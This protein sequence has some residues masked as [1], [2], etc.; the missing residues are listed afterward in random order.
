M[1]KSAEDKTLIRLLGS[2]VS[3]RE[4]GGLTSAEIAEQLGI[5]PWT[6]LKRIRPLIK[7]GV[8]RI[9]RAIGTDMAGR[10]CENIVYTVVKK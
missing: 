3:H 1:G 5:H 2:R 9:T 7:S 4:A 10:R 8:V 6:V